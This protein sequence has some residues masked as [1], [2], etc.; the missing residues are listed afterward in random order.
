MSGVLPSVL[1]EGIL[2]TLLLTDVCFSS[3]DVL[4]L[5]NCE[6]ILPGRLQEARHQGVQA[7]IHDYSAEVHL[8]AAL[9]EGTGLFACTQCSTASARNWATIR[10]QMA[11]VVGTDQTAA[12][13]ASASE[14]TGGQFGLRTV[15]QR[16]TTTYK[17]DTLEACYRSTNTA[18]HKYNT[19]AT[20]VKH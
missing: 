9:R 17:I 10:L 8:E 18:E 5:C 15:L 16:Y 7:F 14:S 11:F 12:G 19:C 2:L 20:P 3:Q 1:T 6:P 4:S 13:V